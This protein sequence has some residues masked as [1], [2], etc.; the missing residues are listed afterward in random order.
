MPPFILKRIF[1]RLRGIDEIDRLTVDI[2]QLRIK[3]KRAINYVR[4]KT[5][6][7]LLLMGTLPLRPEELDDQTLL[8]VDPIGI[9]ADS[10]EQIL[11]HQRDTNERLKM[12]REEIQAIFSAV[13]VGVMVVDA[14]MRVESY[15]PMAKELFF[16]GGIDNIVGKS[17][18]KLL[19]NLN[20][21]PEGCI[22]EAVMSSR[23]AIK[24]YDWQLS[25]RIFDVNAVPIKNKYGDII[26]IVLAYTDTTVRRSMEDALRES[27]QMFRS[28]LENT[29]DIIQSVLPDGAFR[30][31]NKAWLDILGYSHTE[32]TTLTIAD[33]LHPDCLEYIKELNRQI[34]A[35]NQRGI[36]RVLLVA[37][38]G[39]VVPLLG[40]VS[41]SFVDGKLVATCGIFRKDINHIN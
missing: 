31:V 12:V 7:L 17:C 33:I 10:F 2:E 25:G 14:E 37:K 28:I 26:R 20:E 34:V 24:R 8:E 18:H 19:C 30:Y 41:G 21:P 13:G 3:E 38:D 35:G 29:S 16:L 36:V 23:V 27:E 6:Q 40:S 32:V 11:D 9:V 15:N 39:T 1:N 5:N 4:R 22:F